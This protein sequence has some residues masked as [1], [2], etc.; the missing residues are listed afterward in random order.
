MLF[1]KFNVLDIHL[2][3]LHTR[4]KKIHVQ[5]GDENFPQELNFNN[6]EFWLNQNFGKKPRWQSS[7]GKSQN[8]LDHS[9]IKL[10][11]TRF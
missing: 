9:K 10:H 6:I 5:L 4:Q 3:E 8:E 11:R 2:I 1:K 7:V